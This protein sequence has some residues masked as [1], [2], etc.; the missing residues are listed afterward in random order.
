M[1][2]VLL[3]AYREGHAA[4]PDT[5]DNPYAGNLAAARMW[6]LAWQKARA[7]HRGEPFPPSTE[8]DLDG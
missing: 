2:H 5:L 3:R 4:Y 1:D 6:R 8:L 7:E